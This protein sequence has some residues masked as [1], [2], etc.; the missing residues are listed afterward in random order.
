MINPLDNTALA[1]GVT[2]LEDNDDLQAFVFDPLLKLYE[3]QL[4]LEQLLLVYLICQAALLRMLRLIRMR[5]L[6]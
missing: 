6:S 3:L 1:G 2:A 4:Q 5:T